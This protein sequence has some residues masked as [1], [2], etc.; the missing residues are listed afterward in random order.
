MN[1]QEALDLADSMKPNMMQ[2]EVKIRFL[3]ELD[4]MIH[5]EIVL[6]HVHTPAEETRPAYDNDTPG[7]TPLIVPEPYDMLY[8]YWLMTKIDLMNM[9]MDKYN[10]DRALFENQ[11]EQMSDWWTRTRMPVQR[12]REFRL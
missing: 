1:I 9:E 10:N 4:G 2:R 12:T 6:K 11:Y 5:E 3:G 7:D 8:V